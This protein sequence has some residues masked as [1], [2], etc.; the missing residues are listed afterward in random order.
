MNTPQRPFTIL[1]SALGGEGGGVLAGWIVD[2]ATAQ[3]Y[4]VQNTS[5]PGLAQR[6]GATT[7]YIEIFP[8]PR[9]QLGGREPVFAL[10]PSP[11]NL[12]VVLASELLEAGR[13]MQNGYVSPGRTTLIASTNRIYTISE[14]TAMGDGRLDDERLLKGASELAQ[15]AVLFDMATVAEASGTVISAVMFGALAGALQ[16][17]AATSGAAPLSR[18][19]CEDAIGG[20]RGAAASLKGFGAAFQRALDQANELPAEPGKRWVGTPVERVRARFPAAVQRLIEEGVAR[21]TDYQDADYANVYLERME[22]V[23][24]AERRG[25]EAH[26]A[27]AAGQADWAVTREAGR[28][29]ALLMAYEDVIRVADLKTRRSRFER[30]RSEVLAKPGEPVI[31][32]EYLKPGVEE[33]AAILPASLG[34]ALLRRAARSARPWH[35]GLHLRTNT[36]FGFLLLRSMAWLR[37]MRRASLRFAETSELLERWLTEVGQAAGRHPA[38]ALEIAECGRLIKGYGET[39]NRGRGSFLRIL[40]TLVAGQ[41]GLDD[42]AR[43]QAIREARNAALSDPE[44]R[45][46]EGALQRQGVAPLPPAAKPIRFMRKPGA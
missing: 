39:Y 16:A 1:I 5:I 41:P 3:G 22:K 19:A 21:L 6:T 2:A 26:A 46:L 38:L 28:Y 12:D 33:I 42:G 20:S 31:I 10:T 25:L 45:G 4:P 17:G 15:R 7:Y 24:E 23:L 44:G 9:A 32:T 43:A 29:L 11:G 13:A 40:D 18:K 34:R 36:V 8:V 35:V 30:V 37:P 27:P 14:R